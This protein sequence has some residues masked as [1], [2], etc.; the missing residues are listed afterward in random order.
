MK[1]SR[2]LVATYASL[3]LVAHLLSPPYRLGDARLFAAGRLDLW[4]GWPNLS[5][6]DRDRVCRFLGLR[7]DSLAEEG[8]V[9]TALRTAFE[10]TAD[11][12]LAARPDGTVPEPLE[13]RADDTFTLVPGRPIEDRIDEWLANLVRPAT[14]GR[15]EVEW[16]NGE[17][18]LTARD[19]AFRVPVSHRRS[20]GETII[21]LTRQRRIE[22]FELEANELR[23]LARRIDAASDSDLSYE[24]IGIDQ[25]VGGLRTLSSESKMRLAPGP[26]TMLVAPTGS[27]KSVFARLV[28]LDLARRGH[29]V[30]L[31]VPDVA[32]VWKQTQRLEAA[33]AAAGL[34]LSIVPVSS[35]RK[36]ADRIAN[37]LPDVDEHEARWILANAGYVCLLSAYATTKAPEPGSEPCNQLRQR[38][39]DGRGDKAVGCPFAS[40]CGRF[41]T[42]S[43]AARADIVVVNHHAFLLGRNP[44][45]GSFDGRTPQKLTVFDLVMQRCGVVLIDE[46]DTLQN[47]AIDAS[48]RGVSL[49]SSGE[50]SPWVALFSEA[51]SLQARGLLGDDV[52][53]ERARAACFRVIHYAESLVESIGRNEVEKPR[54]GSMTWVEAH[55]K[56][57]SSKLFPDAN[58][59]GKRVRDLCDLGIIDDDP[60]AESLRVALRPLAT[61]GIGDHEIRR[62]RFEVRKILESWSPPQ[63]SRRVVQ[64]RQ[65]VADRLVQRAALVQLDRAI[66]HVRPQ[67]AMLEE[68]GV[69]WAGKLRERLLGYAPW[70]PSPTGALGSRLFGYTFLER[71]RERN[72]VV[73]EARVLAGDPHGFIAELGDTVARARVGQPRIVLGLSATAR[74]AGAPKADVVTTLWGYLPDEGDGLRIRPASVDVRVSGISDR[75]ERLGEIRKLSSQ[76]WETMLQ[77]Y[78]RQVLEH[79]DDSSR[80]RALLVTSSYSEAR[81]VADA[82]YGIQLDGMPVEVVKLVPDREAGNEPGTLPRSAVERFGAVA[83]PALLVAPLSVVARG[84]NILEPGSYRSAIAGIF[85]LTRPVLPT[86]EADRFLAHVSYNARRRSVPW[87]Q[88]AFQTLQEEKRRAWARLRALQHSSAVFGH[89]DAELRL[90]IVCD[91]LVEII[92]LAGRARRGGTSVDVYLVDA[93]FEDALAPWTDLISGV[94]RRWS[95]TKRLPEMLQLHGSIVRALAEYA[96][97][98]LKVLEVK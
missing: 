83:T 19:H 42:F 37:A 20:T 23:D 97:I 61:E 31:A 63:A 39:P 22:S 96:G 67:L 16:G 80:A 93:A 17:V 69:S 15:S 72:D 57:L 47:I 75:S 53:L 54:T 84:H 73:L 90:E 18:L 98:D 14:R 6:Q 46:A 9:L 44:V 50:L 89:M 41:S 29:P 68:R 40:D 92:Q 70:T 2:Q 10:R 66:K 24:K 26:T 21:K 65:R 81:A 71:G 77:G 94:I 79:P 82:L 5:A 95:D 1:Y 52:R 88:G 7:P 38:A 56:W 30:A 3:G 49:S 34:S 60:F 35:W 13:V 78:L 8:T 55:D 76:L 87:A 85:V 25:F 11:F 45:L 86:Q 64:T 27:G 33:A 59:P 12:A 28:A 58:D 4:P 51:Q 43:R 62:V 32:S 91:I 36:S 74:F 48:A